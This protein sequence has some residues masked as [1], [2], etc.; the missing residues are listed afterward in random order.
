MYHAHL[1]QLVKALIIHVYNK[2]LLKK[3]GFDVV[4]SITGVGA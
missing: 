3:N 1:Q 2:V 4:S